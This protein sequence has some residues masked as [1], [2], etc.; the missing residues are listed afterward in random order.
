M[1]RRPSLWIELRQAIKGL[2]GNIVGGPVSTQFAE[3]MIERPILLR[4]VNDVVD[5]VQAVA[6]KGRDYVFIRLE[7]ES[8][9]IAVAITVALG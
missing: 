7:G 2:V 4:H 9:S 6:A 1:R 8:A 5:R 3:I